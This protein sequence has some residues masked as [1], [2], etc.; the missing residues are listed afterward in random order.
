MLIP[1]LLQPITM[2]DILSSFLPLQGTGLAEVSWTQVGR[3]F[4]E[5]IMSCWK[6]FPARIF[7]F[8]CGSSHL[9]ELLLK[10]CCH[11]SKTLIPPWPHAIHLGQAR[12]KGQVL[13]RQ[14]P[15]STWDLAW[16]GNESTIKPHCNTGI[17]GKTKPSLQD[18]ASSLGRLLLSCT[19]T[20]PY[21]T[22]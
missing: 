16:K 21:I 1:E 20:L 18:W 7:W 11:P 14:Y 19:L 15:G 13:R 4:Q 8:K 2:R 22:F 17:L 3:K 5:K 12:K 10:L 9:G 6:H